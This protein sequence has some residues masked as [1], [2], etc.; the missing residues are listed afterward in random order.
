[1]NS[2]QIFSIVFCLNFSTLAA[3]KCSS[4]SQF[5]VECSSL[6]SFN[7][8]KRFCSQYGMSLINLTN[9]TTIS[10]IINQT[11]TAINCT[12]YF[13]YTYENDTGLLG[14]IDSLAGA[15]LCSVI[16][17]LGLY[18]ITASITQAATICLRTQQ[19]VILQKC[20]NNEVNL[21]YDV[22]KSKYSRTLMY[23]SVFQT[24][25]SNSQS[26]CNSLCSKMNR[27]LGVTYENSNCTLY[28]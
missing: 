19:V 12:D 5:Y 1:M 26:R 10:P 13:W 9:S 4:N 6:S 16:P 21:R 24:V 25:R 18:C 22:Q 8:S 20:I 2:F 28:I 23:A 3:F 27:C 14:T 17:L 15:T 11:L 7:D